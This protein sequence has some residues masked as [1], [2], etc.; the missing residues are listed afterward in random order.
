MAGLTNIERWITM[1]KR[2]L[3]ILIVA[4][5]VVLIA[6]IVAISLLD[7]PETPDVPATEQPTTAPTE[8]PTDAPTQPT[9]V[10]TEPPTEAPTEPPVETFVLTF[11]G[12]STL[13]IEEGL[14]GDS[15]SFVK[16]IGTDYG[17]P[18]R[19]VAHLFTTDDCTFTNLEGVFAEKGVGVAQDK[20]FRFRGPLAYTQILTLGSVEAVTLAN[21][22]S[23]DYGEEGYISTKNA[24][25]SVGVHFA[26]HQSSTVFTT[27]SGLKI[28]MYAISFFMDEADLKKEIG[29]MR[30]AGAEII[31]LALH[32]GDEGYYSLTSE[33]Q[34]IAHT[35]IDLGVDIVW[36]HHPHVL[37][38]IEEYNGG[39]IYYSLGNFSFG[40]NRNPRDKDT[41]VLQQQVIR[42]ADGTVHLGELTIIPCRLSSVSSYNDYQP[43]P[44]EVGSVE[45]KRV[46]SKLDGTFDGPDVPPAYATQPTTAP[47]TAP[48]EKPT[49]KPTVA[50]TEKPTVA[51]TQTPTQ[52]PT[53]APTSAP[54][55][56]PT[57]KPTQAPT[58]APTQAPTQKPTAAPTQ[59][60][61]EKP[62]QKPTAAP[63]EAPTEK[64]T[65]A[66]TE[67]TEAPTE[68]PVEPTVPPTETPT[69]ASA[70]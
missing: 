45:Y 21:N 16:T 8:T 10:P 48:T 46:L 29:Q 66:P 18:Y 70:V 64:P 25:N 41:A 38:R 40:G 61:T 68:P 2:T 12:D 65:T 63:T 34:R 13:G 22:H 19:G 5:A 56:A 27:E 4:L 26:E 57:R 30:E 67:P 7:T 55:Q 6:G 53:Q 69:D 49:E 62:T 33:Q 59:A 24:L 32:K 58:A 39:I 52:K 50:P 54:T 23:Y 31:V 9:T 42:E 36:G 35:A 11:T 37:Q 60:P 28:G 43:T 44:Y 15:N 20:R 3:I 17:W 14:W 51:P 1:K 47:T